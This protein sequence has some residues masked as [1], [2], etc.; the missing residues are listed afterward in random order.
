MI[1]KEN[2][3]LSHKINFNT[4]VNTYNIRLKLFREQIS[5]HVPVFKLNHVKLEVRNFFDIH[6]V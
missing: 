2:V 3:N 4:F 5:T 6:S 1:S